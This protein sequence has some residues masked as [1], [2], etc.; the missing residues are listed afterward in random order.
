MLADGVLA[1]FSF[2][3]VPNICKYVV[4]VVLLAVYVHRSAVNL[5][6]F[7]FHSRC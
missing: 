6:V 7:R 4:E 1:F 5:L 3:L 2:S